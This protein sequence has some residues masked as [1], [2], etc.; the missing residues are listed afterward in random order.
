MQ[1]RALFINGALHSIFIYSNIGESEKKMQ[2]ILN[3]A[4]EA[5][6]CHISGGKGTTANSSHLKA[7][8]IRGSVFV[9]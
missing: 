5:R 8:Q 1:I 9:F 6:P 7:Y 2:I 4:A 3:R